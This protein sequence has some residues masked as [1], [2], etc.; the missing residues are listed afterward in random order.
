MS[1]YLKTAKAYTLN[2]VITLHVQPLHKRPD[3]LRPGSL[4]EHIPSLLLGKNDILY[5]IL[6]ALEVIEVVVCVRG[7]KDLW[8]ERAS[9]RFVGL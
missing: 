9:A 7:E 4:R 8:S 5:R 3:M 6:S 2:A 1:H